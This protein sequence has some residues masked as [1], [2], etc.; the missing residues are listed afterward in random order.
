MSGA[1]GDGDS[2]ARASD[3]EDDRGAGSSRVNSRDPDLGVDE[4]GVL[5]RCSFQ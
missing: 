4:Q 2:P 5:G 3:D 1:L